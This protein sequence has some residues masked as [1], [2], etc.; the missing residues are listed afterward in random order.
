MLAHRGTWLHNLRIGRATCSCRF[1]SHM[2]TFTQKDADIL[3]GPDE[4]YPMQKD[5]ELVFFWIG[6]LALSVR[7]HQERQAR[8]DNEATCSQDPKFKYLRT[9]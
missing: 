3:S 5:V 7:T 1:K 6:W 9:A 4:V 2:K 8:L